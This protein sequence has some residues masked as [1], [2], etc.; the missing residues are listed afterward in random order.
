MFSCSSSFVLWVFDD[1]YMMQNRAGHLM[2]NAHIFIG[3]SLLLIG[4]I[5]LRL[6]SVSEQ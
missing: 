6:L 3:L 4:K 1:A 5:E 2:M